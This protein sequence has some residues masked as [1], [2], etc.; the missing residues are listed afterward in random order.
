MG[1]TKKSVSVVSHDPELIRARARQAAQ[2]LDQCTLCPRRCGAK[3]MDDQ[4]GFCGIGHWARVASFGPHFGEE[5]VLVGAGGSGAI[6]FAGC[7]LQCVFCQNHAISSVQA[8]QRASGEEVS[9]AELAGI[10]LDLQHRGCVNINLV[11]PSHVVPQILAALALAAQQGLRLPVVYNSSGYDRV[12]TLRLLD[13]IVQ[14]YMPDCKFWSADKAE[15]Y[16]AAAD[17]PE[18]MRAA[19]VEMHRQ[20][21]DLRVDD[22]G[23]AVSG[24]LV[25]HL[26]MPSLVSETEQIVRFVA[27]VISQESHVNIME[28]Y[29]PCFRARE[30]PEINRSLSR[31]EYQQAM[32]VA[33]AAGLHRLEEPDLGRLLALL[34]TWQKKQE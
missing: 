30:F 33:R 2:L 13:G 4:P 25:R 20:V 1:K 7:N 6:F 22:Q 15:K 32:A 28:Q 27:D 19:L 24:L 11:T 14:I 10:M 21:G 16:L 18:V 17:Y 8:G 23:L 12:E 5:A 9:A 26:V 31:E 34:Q 3:R 29:H